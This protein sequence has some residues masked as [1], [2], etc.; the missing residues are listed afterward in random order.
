MEE[1]ASASDAASSTLSPNIA[2]DGN[3]RICGPQTQVGKNNSRANALRH[4]LTSHALVL[5]AFPNGEL[6]VLFKALKGEWQPETPTEEILVAELARHGAALARAQ[7][8]EFAVLRQGARAAIDLFLL[9]DVNDCNADILLA[10]SVTNEAMDRL[11]RYRRCHEKGLLAALGKL[12]EIKAARSLSPSTQ[13]AARSSLFQTEA[14]CED[15][16]RRRLNSPTHRCFACGGSAG[17]W[18]SGRGRWQCGSCQRQSG[19]RTGTVMAG[20]ALPLKSWF[21]AIGLLIQNPRVPTRTLAT[22]VGT[23]RET[24]ARNI[25]RKIRIAT[26]SRDASLLLAGLDQ[27]F[28]QA[29]DLKQALVEGTILRNELSAPSKVP[30]S[31]SRDSARG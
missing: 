10:G 4:G 8:M 19:L 5:E 7:N 9:D 24:T 12:R 6:E 17:Y 29:N 21:E 14:E 16:L 28:A 2:V 22:A 3:S 30:Y 11:T 1:S 27:V 13:Q 15:Y 31:G 26:M 20:S 18:L 23:K 25:R